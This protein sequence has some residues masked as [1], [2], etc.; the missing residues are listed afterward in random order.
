MKR[1]TLFL[2]VGA[3]LASASPASAVLIQFG[4]DVTIGSNANYQSQVGASQIIQWNGRN[5]P[6]VENFG[7]S[8]SLTGPNGADVGASL[9]SLG[10]ESLTLTTR[11]I[12]SNPGPAVTFSSGTPNILGVGGGDT[13]KFDSNATVSNESWTFD[14]NRD[15]TVKHLVFSAL[16]FNGETI[17]LTLEGESPVSFNRT[18]PLMAPV[19]YGPVS[20]RFVY[21]PTGGGLAIAAGDDITLAST[22]GVWGLQAVVVETAAIPEPGAISYLFAASAATVAARIRR[23]R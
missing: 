4:G 20:Q 12:T 17:Q 7:A 10:P 23:R 15:V 21:T 2:V 22:Q 11:G 3:V 8:G 9:T 16:G 19:T 1:T 18:D 13:A 14:F 6:D 5:S